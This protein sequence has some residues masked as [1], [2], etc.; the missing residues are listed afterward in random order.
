MS[1]YTDPWKMDAL[2]LM[3]EYKRLVVLES[4]EETD[5]ATPY[6]V[7]QLEDQIS[8]RLEEYALDR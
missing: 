3:M 2:W 8:M 6:S 7:S 5:E 1:S 4:K